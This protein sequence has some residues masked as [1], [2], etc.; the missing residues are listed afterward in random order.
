MS[1][2]EHAGRLTIWCNSQSPDVIYE[3]LAEAL[4]VADVRVIV[5][6]V[7]GGFGQKI[8]LI[9]EVLRGAHSADGREDRVGPSSGSRIAAST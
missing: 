5:P 3:P 2:R 6:D 7:G 9:R 8:H 4:G 1:R